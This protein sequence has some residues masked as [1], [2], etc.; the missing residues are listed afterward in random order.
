MEITTFG[1]EWASFGLIC[2]GIAF[3]F[4]MIVAAAAV[5]FSIRAMTG[6]TGPQKRYAVLIATGRAGQATVQQVGAGN[7]A[8]TMGAIRHVKMQLVL[9]VQLAP[10][11]GGQSPAPYVVQ[12]SALI[13]EIAIAKI[14]PGEP[15]PVKVDWNNPSEVVI[16]FAAM[17][18]M[19]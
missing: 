16:D 1:G 6:N 3:V 4:G 2:G 13:P 9:Q 17:G 8:V 5:V 12:M 11:Q 10:D 19:V 7:M 18:Y 15:V 14:Q